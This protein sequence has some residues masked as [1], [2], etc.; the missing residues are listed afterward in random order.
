MTSSWD[1][2]TINTQ[3]SHNCTWKKC[4]CQQKLAVITIA[5]IFLILLWTK[6]GVNK[7]QAVS[8]L[9]FNQDTRKHR[10]SPFLP[11][12]LLTAVK[13]ADVS[14]NSVTSCRFLKWNFI[15]DVLAHIHAKYFWIWGTGTE[16]FWLGVNL[17]PPPFTNDR[18][19]TPLHK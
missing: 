16:F 8:G 5:I 14:K 12:Y 17:P 9:L 13:T 2:C 18:V 19:G 10:K 4:L 1:T 15:Q 11:K 7:P 6:L 3:K